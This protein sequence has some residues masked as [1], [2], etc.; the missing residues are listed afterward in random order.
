MDVWSSYLSCHVEHMRDLFAANELSEG[1]AVAHI[2]VEHLGSEL[3]QRM[4][5]VSLLRW[6]N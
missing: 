2:E 4:R 3:L 6:S 5:P 1:R